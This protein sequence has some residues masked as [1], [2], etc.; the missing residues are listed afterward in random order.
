MIDSS[1]S[2]ATGSPDL[3][4]SL[5][6]LD[7]A[8]ALRRLG[9]RQKLLL[10]LLGE[11]VTDQAGAVD[12]I[13]SL[14]K[15]G[16][17]DGAVRAAHSLKGVAANVGC[18]EL[19]RAAQ[20]AEEVLK[21]G[22]QEDLPGA[23]AAVREAFAQATASIAQLPVSGQ[24]VPVPAPVGDLEAQLTA[25]AGMLQRQDFGAGAMLEGLLPNL[26][27]RFGA[28]RVDALAQAVKRFDFSAAATLL[29]QMREGK[30]NG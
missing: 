3:P 16:D 11:L 27:A 5:P 24:A 1:K 26:R 18:G 23:L 21:Q 17:Q 15:V 2:T 8:D 9:G 30:S 25:L 10:E 29:S 13:E 28:D 20:A 6:G 4:A 14:T 22:R 12:E 7:L 19:S